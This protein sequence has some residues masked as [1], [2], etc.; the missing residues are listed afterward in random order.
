MPMGN[1]EVAVPT[2]FVYQ[3]GHVKQ[4]R[5]I[6][7]IYFPIRDH[8]IREQ[9]GSGCISVSD[10]RRVCSELGVSNKIDRI[11]EAGD[12]VWWTISNNNILLYSPPV[13]ADKLGLEP[14]SAHVTYLPIEVFQSVKKARAA[15]FCTILNYF[16]TP[17]SMETLADLTG[18]PIS[19][20]KI[21]RKTLGFKHVANIAIYEHNGKPLEYHP[22]LE[23]LV[24]ESRYV[25]KKK[26]GS[27][28]VL[29]TVIPNGYDS[30][31]FRTG[32]K[33]RLKKRMHRCNKNGEQ[34]CVRYNR[35]FFGHK[36]NDNDQ[37]DDKNIK[38]YGGQG[39]QL[40][41]NTFGSTEAVWRAVLPYDLDW[42]SVS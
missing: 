38:F 18:V 30:N 24:S 14:I 1:I 17:V 31:H 25:F 28:H 32:F 10:A 8:N 39:S 23:K 16:E 2:R 21:Y 22:E 19:T 42:C 35:V 29:A 33:R 15:F 26:Y 6:A 5:R 11:L 7:R 37:A 36:E 27:K 9:H 41:M 13:I 34:G 20:Q 40:L 3:L 12:G 4:S